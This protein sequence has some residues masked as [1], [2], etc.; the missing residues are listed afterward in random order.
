MWIW[1]KWDSEIPIS[2]GKL[3]ISPKNILTT[4]VA[5]CVLTSEFFLTSIGAIGVSMLF[6]L[7]PIVDAGIS[8]CQ[9]TNAIHFKSS[10][11]W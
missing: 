3:G 4:T 9:N 6:L 2:L 8:F 10:N 1:V 11:V 7:E 5:G